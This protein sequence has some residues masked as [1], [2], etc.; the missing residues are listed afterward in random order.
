MTI[1]FHSP[2]LVPEK[3]GLT[4][5]QV[6]NIIPSATHCMGYNNTVTCNQPNQTGLQHL[7]MKYYNTPF[8]YCRCDVMAIHN[9]THYFAVDVIL[10][11]I[12]NLL[13]KN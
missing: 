13:Y 12:Y 7:L 6:K 10:L 11:S 4:D 8:K 5:G 2:K 1:S 9:S 3:T